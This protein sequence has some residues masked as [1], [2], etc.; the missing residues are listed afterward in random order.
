MN[1]LE[2]IS[3]KDLLKATGISYGQL[4]RW[5]R[6]NLIPEA[7]F[8]KQSSYTGQETFFPKEQILS[9][10]DAI[11]QL[12][13]RY[14][15]EELSGLFSPETNSRTYEAAAVR[16]LPGFHPEAVSLYEHYF[17]KDRFSFME[18]LFIQVTSRFMKKCPLSDKETEQF[19]MC[20]K[21]WIP[22]IKGTD[23]TIYAFSKDG[24]L[25][26]MLAEQGGRLLT[27][28]GAVL[29][30]NVYLEEL[31]KDLNLIINQNMG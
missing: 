23:A 17:L 18:V 21:E 20:A 10:I 22:K 31:S 26:F 15:L 12:R 8:I 28:P 30:D 16:Q 2:Y 27:D 7:W 11:Q 3:K 14:T 9:R 5:K 4:Y 24:A 1:K 25:M 19:V 6:Q 13:D 29:I